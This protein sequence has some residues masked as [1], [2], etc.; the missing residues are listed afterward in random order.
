METLNREF[1]SINTGTL[2]R[3]RF[4]RPVSASTAGKYPLVV[5]AT[6]DGPKGTKSLSWTN[7]PPLLCAKGIASFSFDFEGLGYSEGNRAQLTL[8]RGIDNFRTAFE[9]TRS[10]EWVDPNRIGILA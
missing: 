9:V 7:L 6:G 5:M 2:L 4:T 1:A 10:T 3:G 8:S